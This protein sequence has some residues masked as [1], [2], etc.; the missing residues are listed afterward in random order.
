[1]KNIT[2]KINKLHQYIQALPTLDQEAQTA[3]SIKGLYTTIENSIEPIDDKI[4][5]HMLKYQYKS[6]KKLAKKIER[7]LFRN[8]TPFDV[9]IYRYLLKGKEMLPVYKVYNFSAQEINERLKQQISIGCQEIVIENGLMPSLNSKLPF[10]SFDSL[11]NVA[12][13]F[14][15][16]VK[17]TEL[18]SPFLH[19]FLDRIFESYNFIPYHNFAHA[20]NVMQFFEYMVKRTSLLNN[21]YTAEN[22]FWVLIACICHDITHYGKNNLYYIKKKHNLAFKSLE[23]SVLEHYHC[24]KTL[25]IMAHEDSDIMKY[26][27][28]TQKTRFKQIIIEAILSTDM[29]K[30]FSLIESFGKLDLTKPLSD[31]DFFTL[32]GYLIHSSDVANPALDFDNY[33]LWAELVSQEFHLQSLSEKKHGLAVS[34]FFEYGGRE[35]FLKGQLGFINHFVKPLFKVINDKTGNDEF[36]NQCNENV[37]TLGE[38]LNKKLEDNNRDL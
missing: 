35:A 26:A 14:L 10:H 13:V 4:K 22:K 2:E 1:M 19:S 9:F 28:P 34:P 11:L 32:N 15:N 8:L 38:M 24:E 25:K 30:H 36:E 6:M 27:D 17:P 18:E 3:R 37:K 21:H 16:S 29:S 7:R 5:Y 12:K 33:L 23:K 31:T 20:I